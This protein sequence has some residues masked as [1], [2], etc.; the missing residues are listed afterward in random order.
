[1]AITIGISGGIGS[2]KTTV[3][4]IF[5]LLGIP[6][7]EADMVA[8]E[9]Y[10]TNPK[11]KE[12]MIRL[13]GAGIYTPEGKINRKML[14]SIIFQNDLHLHK[15]NELIHP[16][17]RNKFFNNWLKHYEDSP[18]VILE[19]AILFENG[20]YQMMDFNILVTAPE[21]ARVSRVMHRDGMTEQMVRARMKKQWPEEE[22][23]KLADKILIND[24][25]K[26]MIPEIIQIDKNLKEHGKIW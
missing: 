4:R 5:K 24:N 20:F 9:L 12:E 25:K 21:E 18:Y 26:L 14:A 11:I 16:A 22:K 15:V 8:R 2:G 19:A 13:F 6:V 1:M 3:C 23:E 7:F 17:V 10:N